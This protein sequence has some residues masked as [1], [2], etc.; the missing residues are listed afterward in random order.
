MITVITEFRPKDDYS[1]TELENIFQKLIKETPGET[2]NIAYEVLRTSNT[3]ITYFIIEKW[4]SEKDL[5][6]HIELIASKGYAASAV[7]LLENELNNIILQ[8]LN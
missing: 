5:Q 6:R 3:P 7:G 8:T 2:G 4:A 1:A